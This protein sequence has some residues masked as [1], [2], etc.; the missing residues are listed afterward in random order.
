MNQWVSWNVISFFF[1]LLTWCLLPNT[2]DASRRSLPCITPPRDLAQRLGYICRGIRASKQQLQGNNS[3]SECLMCLDSQ[4]VTGSSGNQWKFEVTFAYLIFF[5]EAFEEVRHNSEVPVDQGI[6]LIVPW[7]NS[8]V[9]L[10]L[11]RSKH[12]GSTVDRRCWLSIPRTNWNQTPSPNRL[13]PTRSI[14]A[15]QGQ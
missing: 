8:G 11:A 6:D 10:F 1:T 4:L 12:L 3:F 13:L 2:T 7:I 9:N 5:Q 15:F 14:T